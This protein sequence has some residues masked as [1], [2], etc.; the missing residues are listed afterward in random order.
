MVVPTQTSSTPTI[1]ANSR[2]VLEL[3]I[4]ARHRPGFPRV[5]VSLGLVGRQA[6]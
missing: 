4:A 3:L 6:R 5:P 1:P 2:S